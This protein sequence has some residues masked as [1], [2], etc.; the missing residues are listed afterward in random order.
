V[1]VLYRG[2]WLICVAIGYVQRARSTR[3]IVYGTHCHQDSK[4]NDTIIQHRADKS[5]GVRGNL[6]VS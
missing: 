1:E 5:T 4:V 2:I 3:K 6:T